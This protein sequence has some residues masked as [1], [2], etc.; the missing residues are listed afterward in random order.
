MKKVDVL[1]LEQIIENFKDVKNLH[2]AYALMK[3]KKI[4]E[5]DRD[6]LIKAIIPI[7][8]YKEF[9][10]KVKSLLKEY[11]L[12]S[13]DEIII[14]EKLV[15][16]EDKDF[17][18]FKTKL[19]NLHLEY[20]AQILGKR[21]QL[22]EYNKFL[23]GPADLQLYKI[24]IKHLPEQLSFGDLYPLIEIIDFTDVTHTST[25]SIELTN[26]QILTSLELFPLDLVAIEARNKLLYNALILKKLAAELM[27]SPEVKN[28]ESYEASR[29]FLAE[30]H[31]RTDVYGD[32]LVYGSKEKTG[33][34]FAIKDQEAFD[35]DLAK[36]N[37]ENEDVLKTFY[38]FIAKKT[39]LDVIPIEKD[40][41]PLNF[42]FQELKAIDVFLA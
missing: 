28:W 31:S 38:E 34:K 27:N 11:C 26:L 5:Q 18:E 13:E 24:F 12:P 40:I 6:L 16:R 23:D 9:T 10:D 7:D 2:F 39:T 20:K 14:V 1:N 29:K 37:E 41:L 25:K 21:D 19:S 42:S 4:I 33:N 3:N 22:R 30:K 35:A 8:S 36:L 15:P 17:E 32:V